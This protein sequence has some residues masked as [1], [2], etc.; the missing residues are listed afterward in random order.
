MRFWD[1]SALVALLIEE[2]RSADALR[3]LTDDEFILTSALTPVEIASALWR[4][5]HRGELTIAAHDEAERRFAQLSRK[6]REISCSPEV[7]RVARGIVSRHQ[8]R[9]LDALQLAA[10]QFAGGPIFVTFD[11]SLASVARGEG[12][13]VIA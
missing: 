1:S 4:R 11:Q 9:S 2:S 7:V 12:L 10:A 13:D 8:I 6:W 5:R 3:A